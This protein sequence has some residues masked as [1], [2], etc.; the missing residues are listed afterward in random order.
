MRTLKFDLHT[1]TNFSPKC[2]FMKPEQL[3]R[4]AISRG[5]DGIAVTDHDTI[6]GAVES[7][8][9][10]TLDFKV[11]VGCELM[12]NKGEIIGLFLDKEIE[13]RD[14]FEAIGEIHEQGGLV[15]VPHPFDELR[16]SRFKGIESIVH[17]VDGIEVFNSRCLK[18]ISNETA[19]DFVTQQQSAYDLFKVSGSDAHFVNEVGSA[20][21]EIS[22]DN[23]IYEKDP[24]SA[25][26]N[27]LLE[28][29]VNV[30]GKR[31]SLLNH[32]GTKILKWKRRHVN[33]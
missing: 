31:S 23:S 32:A 18:S 8:K 6:A 22:V 1:H 19:N 3:V 20:Y 4:T 12:T 27:A 13:S 24:V 2:G 29:K 21:N 17:L 33:Y 25:L 15:I 26:K 16:S 5:L 30:Y 9:F 14:A 10:E 7:K 11:I 28:Q